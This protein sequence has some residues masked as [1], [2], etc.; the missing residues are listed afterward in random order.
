MNLERCFMSLSTGINDFTSWLYDE[1]RRIFERGK[2]VGG[3]ER[4][5]CEKQEEDLD[6]FG[7]HPV[8]TTIRLNLKRSL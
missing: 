2:A 8:L 4:Q 5:I 1:W 3:I 7:D 6:T